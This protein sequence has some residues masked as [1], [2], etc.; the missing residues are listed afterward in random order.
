MCPHDP[1]NFELKDE[2][3]TIGFIVRYSPEALSD[4]AR[5]GALKAR[6]GRVCFL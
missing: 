1:A 4:I 5:P 2:T 3:W 6:C